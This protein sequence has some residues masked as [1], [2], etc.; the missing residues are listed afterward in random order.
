MCDMRICVHRLLLECKVQTSQIGLWP[1]P[2]VLLYAFLYSQADSMASLM[3]MWNGADADAA[4]MRNVSMLE[5]T[6]LLHD[7]ML[8]GNMPS[9]LQICPVNDNSNPHV[10]QTLRTVAR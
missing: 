9:T 10:L 4:W 8:D 1:A 7:Q 6:F 3:T 5:W 2:D